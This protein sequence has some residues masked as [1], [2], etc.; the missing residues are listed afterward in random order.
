MYEGLSQKPKNTNVNCG[1]LNTISN[2]LKRL[3]NGIGLNCMYGFTETWLNTF[4][5]PTFFGIQKNNLT[6]S[7]KHSGEAKNS[8]VLMLLIPRTLTAKLFADF[9]DV[10]ENCESMRVH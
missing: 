5:K 1:K 9:E 3:V 7:Q 8:G 4:P 6:Y 10:F 2:E